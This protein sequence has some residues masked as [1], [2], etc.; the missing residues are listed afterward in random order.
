LDFIKAGHLTNEK[1]NNPPV[2]AGFLLD[3]FFDPENG[4]D[5]LLRNI[6]LS[7]SYTAIQLRTP[8]SS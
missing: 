1:L 7:L 8:Y 6:G 2:S 5:M 3:L 4:G